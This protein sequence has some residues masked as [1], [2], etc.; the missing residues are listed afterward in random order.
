M[1]F[2]NF[3]KNTSVYTNMNFQI[4]VPETPCVIYFLKADV[5]SSLMVILKMSHFSYFHVQISTSLIS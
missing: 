4:T 2:P 3:L 1:E 5:K